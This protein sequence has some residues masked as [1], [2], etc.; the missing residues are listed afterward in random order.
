[1]L[2]RGCT[3]SLVLPHTTTGSR[4]RRR[5]R[6]RDRRNL[7]RP[8]NY[9]P[10]QLSRMRR[11]LY[12]MPSSR[13]RFPRH[14]PPQLSKIRRRL[15]YRPE[16]LSRLRRRTP[17][18]GLCSREPIFQTNEATTRG[19]FL[20]HSQLRVVVRPRCYFARPKNDDRIFEIR[21]MRDVPERNKMPLGEGNVRSALNVRFQPSRRQ[22][23]ACEGRR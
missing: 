5:C 17:Q 1:M 8:R 12:P 23:P 20:Q 15:N 13:L 18:R 16:R 9:L 2:S 19:H 22:I 7:W 11:H 14:P 4:H 10:R 21:I 6:G 3:T